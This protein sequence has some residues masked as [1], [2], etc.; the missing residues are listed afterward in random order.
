MMSFG[1]YI[2][3]L[4][5]IGKNSIYL[6][7]VHAMDYVYGVIWNRTDNHIINAVI[8]IVLD[9]IICCLLVKVLDFVVALP[10]MLVHTDDYN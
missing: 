7:C 10:V 2:K 4:T 8:R 3:P 9:I 6:Y 1:K 5:Y